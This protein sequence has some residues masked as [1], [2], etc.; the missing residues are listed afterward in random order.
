MNKRAEL[1]TLTFIA[2]IIVVAGMLYSVSVSNLESPTG[3]AIFGTSSI[4][5]PIGDIPSPQTWDEDTE[6]NITI[7]DYFQDLE[8][9]SLIFLYTSS[10]R[11]FP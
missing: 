6:L 11:P 2:A 1:A 7:S 3:Y 8:G 9:D 10:L 4:V 5:K